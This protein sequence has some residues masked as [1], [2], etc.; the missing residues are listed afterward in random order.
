M[1]TTAVRPGTDVAE[2]EV[3]NGR[4]QRFEPILERELDADLRVL[5]SGL[6]GAAEGLLS[7][8]EFPGPRGVPD[9]LVVA[10]G[11]ASLRQ[12]IANGAPYIESLADCTVVASLMVNRTVTSVSV[13]MATGMSMEQ[14]E[15][16]LRALAH[17]GLVIVHGQGYRRRPD[18]EPIG[19]TYAFEAKVSDWRRGLSQALRYSAWCDASSLVLLRAPTDID[20]LRA[21]CTDLDI[22]LAIRDEWVRKPRLGRPQPALRLAASERLALEVSRLDSETFGGSIG[23]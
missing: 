1:T 23:I 4:G 15:R 11:F 16:R 14:V 7:V 18:L 21:R 22:G 20:S 8:V 10:R 2:F 9:L 19:R 12:R 5:A 6:P 3:A 13:A 17:S